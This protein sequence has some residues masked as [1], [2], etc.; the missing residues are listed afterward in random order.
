VRLPDHPPT[1]QPSAPRTTY[2][3]F[4]AVLTGMTVMA[5][6]PGLLGPSFDGGLYAL[7]GGRIAA[8]AVPY[9]DVWSEKPPGIYLIN[10]MGALLA[11]SESVWQAA[12]VI[13]VAVV[14]LTSVVV[15]D[16]LRAIGWR[17]GAW[18]AGASCA[19]LLA[20]FPLARGG[21]LTETAAVLPGAIAIRLVGVEPLTAIRTF[22]A[23]LLAGLATTISLL[24]APVLVAVLGVVVVRL[25][26]EDVQSTLSRSVWLVVGAMAPWAAILAGLGLVGVPAAAAVALLRYNA[27]FGVLAESGAAVLGEVIHVILVLSPLAVAALLGLNRPFRSSRLRPVAIGAIVWIAVSIALITAVGRFELHYLAPLAVP[28]SLLLPAGLPTKAHSRPAGRVGVGL[29]WGFLL[30]AASASLILI[31]TETVIALEVR[32]R[33]AARFESVA[34]WI[35]SHIPPDGTLFI[36]GNQT[37]LYTVAQRAPA[38]QYVYL[39]PLMTPGFT[40]PQ[41][42]S[43]ILDRWEAQPP[44][45]ILDAGSA[46]PGQPGMPALLLPRATAIGGLG[47]FDPLDPI[48]D[49]VR[50]RYMLATTLE[51]WPIYVPR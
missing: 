35:D 7:T 42:V 5:L 28:L 10:A 47:D 9:V 4:G 33:Q 14:V 50:E 21:G 31:S 32:S 43:E 37:H 29:A 39:L 6:A 46:A 3:W 26:R 12:W 41:M 24:L 48:R 38:S 22:L 2:L 40:T 1:A 19:L 49:F 44:A 23:G 25:G 8:G 13:S 34:G 15:A 30:A 36:W 20:S 51:G 11:G 27:A 17:R 18:I 45:V 16:T